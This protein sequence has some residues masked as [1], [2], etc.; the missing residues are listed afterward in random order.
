MPKIAPALLLLPFS[1]LLVSCPHPSPRTQ[2]QAD[3]VEGA[4][5]HVGSGMTFPITA[6]DF[7]RVTV[8]KLDDEG[9]E[10]GAEYA[11]AQP[12]GSTFATVYVYP[13][14]AVADV[15]APP[16]TVS[17]DGAMLAKKE[18]EKRKL[19]ILDAHPG[20]RLISESN[21][22]ATNWGYIRLGRIATFEYEDTATGQMLRSDLWVYHFFSVRWALRY[23]ITSPKTVDTTGFLANFMAGVPNSVPGEEGTR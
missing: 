10:I 13:A 18:F 22:A 21:V 3:V 2:P 19:A 8:H 6:G 4:Y 7:R 12:Q 9:L 1:I 14:V 11:F 17:G 23:L 15:G 16:G 5:T 20:T